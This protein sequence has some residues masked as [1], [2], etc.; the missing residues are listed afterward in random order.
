LLVLLATAAVA[1]VA[2]CGGGDGDSEGAREQTV[3]V[4]PEYAARANAICTEMRRR[5][6]GLV[7]SIG[8]IP[9]GALA[10][11]TEGLVA[12]GI[13][14]LDREAARLRAL[15]PRPDNHE[16]ETYLGLFDPIL[17]LSEE[18]LRTGRAG[19][20]STSR[21]LERLVTGLEQ[22]QRGA[23]LAAGLD[24]CGVEFVRAL[25]PANESGG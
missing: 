13:R 12:P 23:A 8:T 3:A 25:G 18:R 1:A 4:D 5:K 2:G 24:Q 9:G 21:T 6:R 14:I 20:F 16:L 11:I 17:V 19:D 15:Q 10:A 7:K 22:R